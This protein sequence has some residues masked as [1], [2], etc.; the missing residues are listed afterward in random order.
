MRIP[1]QTVATEISGTMV[2]AAFTGGSR[3]ALRLADLR[4]ASGPAVAPATCRFG[5]APGAVWTRSVRLPP[6]GTARARRRILAFEVE[7]AFP[8]AASELI[9]DSLPGPGVRT[10]GGA[11]ECVV[12]IRTADAGALIG[13]LRAAGLRPAALEP[14]GGPLY[15]C[16]RY[17][18]P[19][20]RRP[21]VIVARV[22]G[23]LQVLVTC[24][25]HWM[26]RTV[27]EPVSAPAPGLAERIH[28]EI[29]RLLAAFGQ[30]CVL[31]WGRLVAGFDEPDLLG[32]DL[33][34]RLRIPVSL[35]DPLARVTCD[36]PA[37]RPDKG[38]KVEAL[39]VLVGLAVPAVA[40]ERVLDL[41]PP[42][43]RREQ[44]R[45]RRRPAFFA[46]SAVMALSLGAIAAKAAQRTNETVARTDRMKRDLPVLLDHWRR[47]D[48]NVGAIRAKQAEVA[49]WQSVVAERDGWVRFLR[50]LQHAMDVA[51]DAWIDRLQRGGQSGENPLPEVVVAGRLLASE[52]GVGGAGDATRERVRALLGALG[53]SPSVA[54]I[55]GER[56]SPAEA[57]VLRFELIVE[58]RLGV[59]KAEAAP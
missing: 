1:C 45:R 15:R 30:P 54:R 29:A 55:I 24:E 56:F 12:S 4:L 50:D 46:A 14:P 39:P 41:L 58:L 47:I 17:N 57:G 11:D 35:L 9:W 38:P 34:R 2:T 25:G 53:S 22:G 19:A 32:N 31:S 13:R 27:S 5:L 51:G 18:E 6:A 44:A 59:P 8:V 20:E 7:R 43:I 48:A 10:D 28:L 3:G 33:E 23:A 49:I 26:L 40:G 52:T 36:G 16:F 21:G 42:A 37:Q